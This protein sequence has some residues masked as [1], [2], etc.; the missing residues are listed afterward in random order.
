ESIAKIV[1]LK[2]DNTSDIEIY[3]PISELNI[4]EIIC[5]M[6]ILVLFKDWKWKQESAMKVDFPNKTLTLLD[7]TDI[8]LVIEPKIP[9]TQL[10]QSVDDYF[11]M[12]KVYAIALDINLDNQDLKGTF[13][14]GLSQDNKKEVIRFGFKNSL[15]EIVD[16]LNKISTGPTDIQKFRFGGL[17]QGND[18]VMEYFAKV[19]KCND[20]LGYD[21]EHLKHQFLRGLN[22][23]NHM[24]ARRCGLDLPLDELVERLS[25]LEN[26]EKI[27]SGI[28]ASRGKIKDADMLIQAHLKI[29]YLDF[30][31]VM[32]FRNDFL[33]VAIIRS[34]PNLKHFNIS[35]NDVGDEVVEALAHTCHE[36][37]YLDLGGCDFITEP[38][39]C[40]V[41]L[42]R[43]NPS[44]HIENYDS[45]YEQSDSGSSDTS[46][47]DPNDNIQTSEEDI[48]VMVHPRRY[49]YPS[50]SR[51]RR[52]ENR[53]S[54][55]A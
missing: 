18:S 14:N 53:I 38:S 37:E 6:K 50:L 44:I 1:G 10:N 16:H 40:N 28:S 24:E 4:L 15:N 51:N 3:G 41:I 42:K 52:K 19:K 20:S 31:G 21:E 7:G 2:I 47:S 46:D 49:Y 32:A 29:E 39:I 5:A 36:I 22:S 30:A 35:H 43:L 9:S 11:K 8:Q 33:I 45:S 34:S 27:Q 26:I 23:D 55:F 12:I 17:E 25:T 48:L 13:F 54:I